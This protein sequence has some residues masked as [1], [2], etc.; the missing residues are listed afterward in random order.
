MSRGK[1]IVGLSRNPIL[2]STFSK[3]DLQSHSTIGE[4]ALLCIT[5][6]PP[7]Y[8]CTNAN[9]PLIQ[10]QMTI[11]SAP[12]NIKRYIPIPCLPISLTRT[13]PY[14]YYP[15]SK[16]HYNSEIRCPPYNY[17]R[18]AYRTPRLCFDMSSGTLTAINSACSSMLHR[19][20]SCIE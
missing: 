13:K 9:T 18:Q 1:G 6:F 5:I 17:R 10:V 15:E 16:A 20:A 8:H 4:L 11:L 19:I 2:S 7:R 14:I 3:S 12:V